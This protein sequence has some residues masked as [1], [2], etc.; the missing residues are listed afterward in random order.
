MGYTV[1]VLVFLYFTVE[2][3]L[4]KQDVLRDDF[5]Y[6]TGT[7]ASR[8]FSQKPDGGRNETFIFTSNTTVHATAGGGHNVTG[9]HGLIP[10]IN[11]TDNGSLTVFENQQSQMLTDLAR[12]QD[13]IALLV[14]SSSDNNESI[15]DYLIG[16]LCKPGTSLSPEHRRNVVEFI[17][18]TLL[19]AAVGPSQAPDIMKYYRSVINQRVSIKNYFKSILLTDLSF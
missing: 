2:I 8:T 3:S 1:F 10:S 11:C 13:F 12:N 18:N 4:T 5:E 7:V 14:V 17:D 6:I 19:A 16:N 15:A 9:V